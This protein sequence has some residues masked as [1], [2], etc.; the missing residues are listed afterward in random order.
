MLDGSNQ[1]AIKRWTISFRL[2]LPSSEIVFHPLTERAIAEML[3]ERAC[4][5]TITKRYFALTFGV[6]GSTASQAELDGRDNL[7]VVLDYIGLHEDF[8]YEIHLVDNYT[9]DETDKPYVGLAEVADILDV[10][11]QRAHQLAKENTTFPLPVANLR[12]TRVWLR[13]DIQ[14]FHAR[15]NFK[16]FRGK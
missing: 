2:R 9:E 11:Q 15:R 3:D 1:G 6:F 12:A 5:L 8:I 16:H 4:V 13:T 7:A 14:E 10:S